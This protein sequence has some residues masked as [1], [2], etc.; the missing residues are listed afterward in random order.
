MSLLFLFLSIL[1]SSILTPRLPLRAMSC[2]VYWEISAQTSVTQPISQSSPS[3][4]PVY[5]QKLQLNG[6]LN[7]SIDLYRNDSPAEY[8]GDA[9]VWEDRRV[10]FP[11]LFCSAY[12][13]PH[14][15][16]PKVRIWAAAGLSRQTPLSAFQEK[17]CADIKFKKEKHGIQCIPILSEAHTFVPES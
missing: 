4:S 5:Q 2:S 16:E 8:S 3:L 14:A 17:A 11:H 1:L 10:V 7:F 6:I 13:R 12:F 9:G 15:E